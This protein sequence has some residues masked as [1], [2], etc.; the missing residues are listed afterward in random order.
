MFPERLRKLRQQHAIS[1]AALAQRLGISGT[2]IY[3]WETG[4]CEPD[5]GHIQA[6]CDIFEVTMDQ[7]CGSDD[8]E[9]G[10]PA[11]VMA[12]AIRRM[13]PQEQ[14]ELLSLSRRLFSRAF[15]AAEEEQ[16]ARREVRSA[17]EEG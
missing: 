6:L 4:Q 13:T 7:L 17:P 5:I 8:L 16:A 12:R 10:A 14:E 1:R 3:K 2:L 11:V 9:S 15:Q